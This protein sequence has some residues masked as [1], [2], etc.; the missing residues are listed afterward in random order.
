MAAHR[1]WRLWITYTTA[2]G[3]SVSMGEIELRNSIGGSDLT[4][5]GTASASSEFSGSFVASNAVDNNTSTSWVATGA[6]TNAAPEWWKYDF[7]IGVTYDIVELAITPR[8]GVPANTPADFLIQYS[9]DNSVWTTAREVR[10]TAWSSSQRTIPVASPYGTEFAPHNMTN[11]TTPSPYVAAESSAFSSGFL[12]ANAF[13]GLF[14]T[15][16]SYWVSSSGAPQ[17]VSIDLGSGNTHQCGWYS[18]RVNRV[19][20]PNRAPKDFKLQGSNN[21]STWTDLDTRTGESSWLAGEIRDYTL[22]STSAAYRY[23]R[24]NISA[25][26]GDSLIQLAEL[27]LYEPLGGGGGGTHILIHSGMQGG[28]KPLLLGGFNG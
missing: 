20:E 1:Y 2:N 5:S 19:P 26:N 11:D 18:I 24:L 7:G 25:N 14:Q 4:G 23:Y 13:D 22:A 21:N 6:A 27:Y 10:L 9:D 16:F 28:I 3:G 12:G 15:A 17:W 8:T